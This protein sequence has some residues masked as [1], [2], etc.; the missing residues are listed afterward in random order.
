MA[1]RINDELSEVLG[2]NKLRDRTGNWLRL[3]LSLRG[4]AGNLRYPGGS[5]RSDMA[6]YINSIPGL[7]EFVRTENRQAFLSED[8]FL[9]L[10][11]GLRQNAWML[12]YLNTLPT[13]AYVDAIDASIFL[14]GRQRIIALFDV[15]QPNG[16]AKEAC[17][18]SAKWAWE[19]Q[20]G[21]DKIF[22]W[23]RD[24]AGSD[25]Y[26][27]MRTWLG[28]RHPHLTL[29]RWLISNHEELLSFFDSNSFEDLEI[30]L[31]M[32]ELKKAWSQKKYRAKLKDRRQCNLILYEKT[33]TQLDKLSGKY[34]LSRAELLE[35]LINGEARQE[36]YITQK[37]QRRQVL[38]S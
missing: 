6:R 13:L 28:K 14:S 18:N 11:D 10:T 21:K 31:M 4:Q 35:L 23:F 36:V 32:M 17:V 19:I 24:E 9:W 12:R 5:S 38:V 22:D 34:D 29:D 2:D 37:L 25:G 16:S 8:R 33:I 20:V 26:A 27:L 1:V 3:F 7:A 30:K 15:Y